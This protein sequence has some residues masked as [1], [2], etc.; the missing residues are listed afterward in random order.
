M[1]QKISR[2]IQGGGE[3]LVSEEHLRAGGLP[4][5]ELLEQVEV[6]SEPYDRLV[7]L[8]MERWDRVIVF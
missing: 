7:E 1:A 8:V 3:V 2:F 6:V 4:P 5:E